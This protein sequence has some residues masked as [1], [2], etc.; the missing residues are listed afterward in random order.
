LAA[1]WAGVWI[2]EDIEQIADRRPQWRLGVRHAR[3]FGAGEEASLD[4][5]MRLVVA[6][7]SIARSRPVDVVPP[8]SVSRRSIG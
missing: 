6:L 7:S 5:V 1:P 3:L 4:E 8:G 2:A